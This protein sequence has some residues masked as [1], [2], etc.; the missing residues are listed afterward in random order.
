MPHFGDFLI[1]AA[2]ACA[3]GSL[4][5]YLLT[6]RGKD[7]NLIAGR[8][9]FKSTAALVIAAALVL[10]YLILA[11]DFSVAYV[12]AYSSSDL[13]LGYLIS[14]LWAGQ[15]G[16]FLL[17]LT[18]VTLMGL[19]MIK[20]AGKFEEGNMV[21]VNL[22]VLSL[23][24]I[25]VK[26]S[27]FEL[28][29]VA[30]VEGAG[31]NPLLQNF[32]MQI[33]PPIM[34]VG[35]AATL[36]P[37]AF[38]VTG[39]IQRKY[40]TWAESARRWTVFAWASLGT[41]LV[42][43]GY[44]AYV[45]LG[46]GGFW[47]WDPV[48]NS[49]F[50]PWIFLT[51]QIHV[52]FIQRKR[53]GLMRFSLLMVCLSFWSVLYGTFLTRSGVLAD[54]SVH[55]FVDLG[56]NGF[57]ISSLFFF[58]GAGLFLIVWRWQDIKPN[59]SFS[60][61]NSRAYIVA[62]GVVMLF[63]GGMLTLLGTSAP[64]LT[65]VTDNPS[66][67]G[68]NYYF[69]TM[70]PVAVAVLVLIGLFPAFRWNKGLSKPRLLGAGLIAAAV[71]IAA[72]LFTGFT[73]QIIYLLFFAAAAMAFVSNSWV[74][75]VSWREGKFAPGYLAHVGLAVALVGAA[76]SAGFESKKTVTLLENHDVNEM[77]YNLRFARVVDK[78][79]GFDC[80]VQVDAEGS[81]FTAIL[82]HEFPR[83][84]QGV[85][86]RP[87][88]E[89]F[90]LLDV[91]ISPVAFEPSTAIDRSVLTL[92]KDQSARIDE[93]EI[94]FHDFELDSHGNAGPASVAATLTVR[95]DDYSE[96]LAPSL[97]V[98][99]TSVVALPA[100]F[101][102]GRGSISIAGIQPEEGAVMLHVQGGFVPASEPSGASLVI[103]IS[104]KPLINLFWLGTTICFLSGA[105]SMRK[106]RKAKQFVVA[107]Q[108]VALSRQ[109]KS[110]AS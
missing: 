50:I 42:M 19:V 34:F 39:L 2:T 89:K 75:A 10:L 28:L 48:E 29:S 74:L 15:E 53:R 37:F 79:D 109:K 88:V 54:F 1:Y 102:N 38:A 81:Q 62:L 56:I 87:H 33:H 64:L 83:N 103:E 80:H 32:W 14:T 105:L 41:S 4:A 51:T 76:V 99:S 36:F 58:I 52:L 67:V 43:G 49:S 18:Y 9:L 94:T 91:Y 98:D 110:V 16:T 27:P 73:H 104:K 55:S 20:T 82:P 78:Q 17:W 77:G 57:L 46:W 66:N 107:A 108:E 101:A 44:W 24:M 96:Q 31:L 100:T 35:F 25:L 61:V 84:A 86:R 12:F 90:L 21:V 60:A 97:S 92:H 68:L 22:F 47:A 59:P 69:T 45:T 5:F 40:D 7:A 95:Y 70:T 6:L 13:P 93:Y 3:L 8:M 71:T 11:H 26:K 63:M 85:M 106:R 72:L 30:Q 23:L 65:R